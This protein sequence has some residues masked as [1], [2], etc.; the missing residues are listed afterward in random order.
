MI[1]Q[2]HEV[3]LIEVVIKSTLSPNH[4]GNSNCSKRLQKTVSFASVDKNL[5]F[6]QRQF[7]SVFPL[8]LF[9]INSPVKS[10]VRFRT[11]SKLLGCL[12]S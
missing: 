1:A 5:F 3:P 7:L 8:S 9:L 10:Q 12:L 6:D 11:F 2:G 4:P